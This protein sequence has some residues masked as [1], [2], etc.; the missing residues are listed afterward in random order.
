MEIG[1]KI[2][3]YIPVK[4]RLIAKR[5]ISILKLEFMILYDVNIIE[6]ITKYDRVILG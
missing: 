1:H 2:T 3:A 4:I 6:S 5:S